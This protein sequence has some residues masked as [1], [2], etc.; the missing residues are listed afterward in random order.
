MLFAPRKTALPG[1]KI[2]TWVPWGTHSSLRRL[3]LAV[4]VIA[5]LSKHLLILLLLRV[6]QQG[7]DLAVGILPDGLCLGATVLRSERA[8]GAQA[9]HL[10][11]AIGEKGRNLRHLIAGKA[12]TLAEVRGHLVGIKVA[13]IVSRL[14]L[15]GLRRVGVGGLVR[16]GRLRE[17]DAR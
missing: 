10:L 6:V 12:E 1:L 14:R 16:V 7:L 4:L 15:R 9:L 17:Q 13:V 8:V 2:Q 3:G 11:L 5:T